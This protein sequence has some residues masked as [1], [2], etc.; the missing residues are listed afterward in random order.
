VKVVVDYNED[1]QNVGIKEE[2]LYQPEEW[3]QP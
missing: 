2:E 1:S 3:G